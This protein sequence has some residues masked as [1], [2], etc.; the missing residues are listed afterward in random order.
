MGR[1]CGYWEKAQMEA[2]RSTAE[3]LILMIMGMGAV[4]S[5]FSAPEKE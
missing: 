1:A 5:V 4:A 2:P 3:E